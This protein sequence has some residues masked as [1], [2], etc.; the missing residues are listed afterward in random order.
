[1]TMASATYIIG[2]GAG[3]IAAPDARMGADESTA[4]AAAERRI[5]RSSS[6]CTC[7]ILVLVKS[8]SLHYIPE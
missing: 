8:K 1:M 5:L 2:T 7:K 3:V 6:C 4:A